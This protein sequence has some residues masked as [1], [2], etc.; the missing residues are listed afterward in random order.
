M[1]LIFYYIL[2]KVT[3]RSIN[4][5][6]RTDME[7]KDIDFDKLYNVAR[8]LRK[9]EFMDSGCWEWRG[10]ITNKHSQI[11]SGDKVEYAHRYI[12]KLIGVPLTRKDVVCHLCDNPMCVNPDHLSVGNTTLNGWDRNL[13]K[14]P[15]MIR[16]LRSAGYDVAR[17]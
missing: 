6:R 2:T 11:R 8:V 14:I 7:I 17:K 5:I 9:V 15:Q 1:S 3:R 10:A 4:V 12:L 16:L 13:L